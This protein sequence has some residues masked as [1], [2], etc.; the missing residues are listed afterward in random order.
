MKTS[1]ANLHPKATLFHNCD[2]EDPL[3]VQDLWGLH[4]LLHFRVTSGVVHHNGD[5]LR[6][7]NLNCRLS[8]MGGLHLSLYNGFINHRTLELHL[9]FQ[10]RQSL[11][12]FEPLGSASASRQDF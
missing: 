1:K 10:C 7:R 3:S 2:I 11:K 4:G 6:L 12:A 9:W 8:P 5:E